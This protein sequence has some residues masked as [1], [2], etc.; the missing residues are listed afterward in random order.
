M[1]RRRLKIFLLVISDVLILYAALGLT[2]FIRYAIIE[3]D[4]PTLYSS[5][6]LHLLPFTIIFFFWLIIFWAA[7]L[8]DI[9]KLRNEEA[10]YKTLLTAFGINAA[11]TVTFF[12]FIPYF[13]ITPK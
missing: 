10:F 7:G 13:I 8:Y 4:L 11:I 2:L 9:I 5:A 1:W 6:P 12:Y 3:R